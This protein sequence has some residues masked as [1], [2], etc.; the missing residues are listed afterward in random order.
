M[1]FLAVIIAQV[2]D[3]VRAGLVAL[4]LIF[5]KLAALGAMRWSI[6]LLGLGL[7]AVVLPQVALG[8]HGDQAVDAA[9]FGLLSNAILAGIVISVW[10]LFRH[11]F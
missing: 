10:R 4:V 3:P 9:I 1:G 7:V 11:W 5:A 6:A 2:L 8:L